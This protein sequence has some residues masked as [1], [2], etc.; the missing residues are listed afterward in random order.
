[1][2]LA[3]NF[4]CIES[5]RA[6]AKQGKVDQVAESGIAARPQPRAVTLRGMNGATDDQFDF[7][8]GARVAQDLLHAWR[9]GKARRE[10]WSM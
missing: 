6:L 3:K 7:S 10:E 4:P 1:M 5:S 2:A 8:T 9:H